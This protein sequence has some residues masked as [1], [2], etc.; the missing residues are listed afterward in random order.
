MIK[1]RIGV[2]VGGT[3]IRAALVD[4]Q[5]KIVRKAASQ[6]PSG[7][8]DPEF[9]LEEIAGLIKEVMSP[10]VESIG[11]G[12]PS[13]VDVEKGIV[14]NAANIPCWKEVHLKEY[15]SGLF[16]GIRVSVNNDANCFAAGEAVYG[17][18]KGMKNV[19]GITIGT[20]TGAGIMIDGNLYNGVN[21]CAGEIGY[22]PYLDSYYENYTSGEFFASR[23]IDAREAAENAR[24][25]NAEMVSLWEEFGRHVG[26]LIKTI[27]LAY[28][29]QSIVLGGGMTGAS[30][31]FEKSMRESLNDFYYPNV[32][33]SVR[34]IFSDTKDVAVLGAAAI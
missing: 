17:S 6:C 23:G 3:N 9:V 30:D 20:G 22:F 2:D 24:T 32:S 14:Y 10:D 7:A 4:E 19:V 15:L 33:S 13:I 27:L 31:L 1:K 29:P 34:I 16:P 5:G 8:E 11:V 28:D 21:V 26:S 12:V 25:G 18:A